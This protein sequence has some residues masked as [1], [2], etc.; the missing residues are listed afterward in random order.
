MK[1]LSLIILSLS[2]S[3]AAAED[4]LNKYAVDIDNLLISKLLPVNEI[5]TL[6]NKFK[7]SSTLNCAVGSRVYSLDEQLKFKFENGQLRVVSSFISTGNIIS[8]TPLRALSG[9]AFRPAL[10]K[11]YYFISE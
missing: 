5:D 3:C 4:F 9:F 11:G 7:P 8:Y 1:I 2:F 10:F 6:T